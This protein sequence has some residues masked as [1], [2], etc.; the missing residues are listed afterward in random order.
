MALLSKKSI[1]SP[2]EAVPS[3]VGGAPGS[4]AGSLPQALVSKL[5]PRATMRFMRAILSQ[6]ES[7]RGDYRF[8]VFSMHDEFIYHQPSDV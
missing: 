2:D 5:S 7:G 8:N 1:R 6:R 4:E 3:K